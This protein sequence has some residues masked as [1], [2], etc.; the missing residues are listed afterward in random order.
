MHISIKQ[1]DYSTIY[2]PVLTSNI[3]TNPT[4]LFSIIIADS[5]MNA[6][7][8]MKYSKNVAFVETPP[9]GVSKS[10]QKRHADHPFST[11]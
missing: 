6:D 7:V 11:A 5:E 9:E 8:R 10:C 2:Y 3:H 1:H 4:P